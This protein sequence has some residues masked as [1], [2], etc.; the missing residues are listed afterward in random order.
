MG[1]GE[2][3]GGKGRGEGEREDFGGEKGGEKERGGA[4]GEGGRG[5]G[6]GGGNVVW[7]WMVDKQVCGWGGGLKQWSDVCMCVVC[8]WA[9]EAE[10]RAPESHLQGAQGEVRQVSCPPS[11]NFN[12]MSSYSC[13]H[14][15]VFILV[16]LV[17]SFSHSHAIRG[18]CAKTEV[19]FGL[20][21]AS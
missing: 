14:T 5:K 20:Y 13:P 1:G 17:A 11:H 21:H 3:R 19:C 10:R 16:L 15:H 6:K 9:G 4:R 12:L 7:R 8:E 2:G 18:E